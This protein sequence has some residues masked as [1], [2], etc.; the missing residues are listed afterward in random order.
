MQIEEKVKLWRDYFYGRQDVFATKILNKKTNKLEYA[1]TIKNIKGETI[2]EKYLPLGDNHIQSHIDGVIELMV[3]VLDDQCNVRFAVIDFDLNHTFNDALRAHDIITG[4]HHF[5]S[6]IARSTKKG[7]HLYMFFSEPIEAHVVVSYIAHVYGLLGWMDEMHVRAL[8]ETFPKTISLGKPTATANG[9]IKF[10]LGFGV[11]PPMWGTGQEKDRN[12]WVDKKDRPIGGHGLSEDQWRYM[13]A[14]GK[15]SKEEL[16]SFLKDSNISIEEKRLSEKRGHIVD[17]KSDVQTSIPYKAPEDGDFNKILNGCPA[18]KRLWFDTAKKEINHMSHVAILSHALACE[19]GLE[20]VKDYWRDPI[21]GEISPVAE[22]QIQY[23][24]NTNQ[25][26]WTCATM[27]R[28]GVCVVGKDPK[29]SSGKLVSPTTGE[30]FND[31]CFEK[32]APREIQ[33]GSRV[34][35]PYNLPLSQWPDPSPVRLRNTIVRWGVLDIIHAIEELT[36]EDENLQKKVSEIIT[37]VNFLED[38]KTKDD[39]IKRIKHKKLVAARVIDA[40]IKNVKKQEKQRISDEKKSVRQRERERIEARKKEVAEELDRDPTVAT[41]RGRHYKLLDNDEGY[42]QITQDK[43]GNVELDIISNFTLTIKKEIKRVRILSDPIIY[44][45]GTINLPFMKKPF[46]IETNLFGNNAE[47]SKVLYGSAGSNIDFDPKKMT[48]LRS[49][50]LIFGSKDKLEKNI[51]ENH[52]FGRDDNG[53][54]YRSGDIVISGDEIQE[55]DDNNIEMDPNSNA[56]FLKL[57]KISQDDF[58]YA[59]RIILNDFLNLDTPIVMYTILSHTLQASIHQEYYETFTQRSWAPILWLQ[60]ITGIGKTMFGS[61]CQNFYGEFKDLIRMSSTAKSAESEIMHFKDALCLLDDYK[62]DDNSK[63]HSEILALFQGIYDRSKRQRLRKTLEHAAGYHCRGLVMVTGEGLFS[64]QSS[65]HS[66]CIVVRMHGKKRGR[67]KASL[68]RVIEA[69]HL[70]PGVT[71][72]FIQFILRYYPEPSQLRTRFNEHAQMIENRLAKIENIHRIVNN[73]SA[74]FLTWELFLEF[75]LKEEFIS[76]SEYQDHREKH[77][78]NIFQLSDEMGALCTD[79][80][81]C[82]VFLSTIIQGL[83]SNHVIIEGLND[84]QEIKPHTFIVGFMEDKD[85]RELYLYPE[86]AMEYVKR[87]LSGG[88]ESLGHSKDAIGRQLAGLGYILKTSDS[89][90]TFRKSRNGQRARLWCLDARKAGFINTKSEA[91]EMVQAKEDISNV[92]P[93]KFDA[94]KDKALTKEFW[95]LSTD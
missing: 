64:N 23:G 16:I 79:N 4:Q 43:K 26:P 84:R 81:G 44:T 71:A 17:L 39:C 56:S 55:V 28:Y 25:K 77:R 38:V 68:E 65:F 3:Y 67:N 57:K 41:I 5:P 21:T 63:N 87:S 45:E 7:H 72:R 89:A 70:F 85:D 1:P 92:I 19:N 6:A 75:M 13:K 62:D 22:T 33:N 59:V 42:A 74:N 88:G 48:E 47:L 32:V 27:Q 10:P 11:K 91:S 31:Y 80:L 35:N 78:H 69:Q 95:D 46:K 90:T 58:E 40:E 53:L 76:D 2:S 93:G 24:I 9:V 86:R 66:R 61:I 29:K 15:I 30:V 37:Q 18:L 54:I 36:K 73:F 8:P 82:I 14:I 49:C 51:D 20:M 60:A 94:K 12:C 34:I 50:A 52:G 83:M